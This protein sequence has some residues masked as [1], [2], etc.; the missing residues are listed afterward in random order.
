[1]S[2][3]FIVAQRAIALC[4][5][6]AIALQDSYAARPC[7]QSSPFERWKWIGLSVEREV[8]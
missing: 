8:G 3:T 1:M 5:A 2:F 4:V 6:G 7:V